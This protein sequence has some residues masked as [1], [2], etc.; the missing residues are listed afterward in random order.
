M[1]PAGIPLVCLCLAAACMPASAGINP[2]TLRE[3]DAYMQKAN[4][5]MAAAAASPSKFLWTKQDPARWQLLMRG[6]VAVE[7]TVNGPTR[8]IT[9][10]LIHDWTGAVFVPGAT[11][12]D[13]LAVLQDV[14]SH[15]V[16]YSPDVIDSKLLWRKGDEFASTL[17][18]YKKKVITAVLD[19]QF[20][21]VYR[22]L[23]PTR[24]QGT[25][26][27]TKIVEVEDF[28]TANE[29]QK[30]EGEG[31][32]FLW[33]LNSWWNI[34]EGEGGVTLE[35]RSISL[36]RDIPFGLSWVIKPMVTGL[37]RETLTSSLIKTR[38]AVAD[39]ALQARPR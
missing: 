10:G 35:L 4:S 11:A 25:I 20:H 22:K 36:T 2:A 17:R 6:E 18:T 29:R 26:R 9:G 21:T 1:R 13:A 38:A 8:D 24:H 30:P 31:F 23:S 7:P 28:G 27:S 5:S 15:K 33:R 34:E 32:G 16:V 39:R 14:S 37:P 12:A 19:N 3:F